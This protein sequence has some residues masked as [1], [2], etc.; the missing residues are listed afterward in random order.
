MEDDSPQICQEE[1]LKSTMPSETF[2][3]ETSDRQPTASEHCEGDVGGSV[4]SHSSVNSG[5]SAVDHSAAAAAIDNHSTADQACRSSVSTSW[6]YRLVSA[7]LAFAVWGGWGYFVNSQEAASTASPVMSGLLH[8]IFSSMVTIVMLT[9]VTWLY[10]KF[11]AAGPRML[12][13]AVTTSVATGSCITTAH[14]IIGTANV[15]ATVIPGLVVAFCFNMVTTK[16]LNQ[17]DQNAVLME[18][19]HADF[20][21]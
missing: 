20:T 1:S 2:T 19:A 18:S 13:P 21:V 9:S 16:K 5:L 3:A 11:A 6:T 14:V 4:G 12:I 7:G 10:R 17:A 8:G 15:P